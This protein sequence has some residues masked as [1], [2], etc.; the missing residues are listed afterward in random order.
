VFDAAQ[1]HMPRGPDAPAVADAGGPAAA[2]PLSPGDRPWTPT[3]RALRDGI[4]SWRR[5]FLVH[6]LTGFNATL[7]ADP[8]MHARVTAVLN[9]IMARLGELDDEGATRNSRGEGGGG[10]GASGD[11][12]ASA[13]AARWSPSARAAAAFGW[14]G[15]RV[16]AEDDRSR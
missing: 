16:A 3:P 14:R 10:V 13:S 8:R 12:A 15:A 6:H 5:A 11:H 2:R 4:D 9:G 1:A 7:S